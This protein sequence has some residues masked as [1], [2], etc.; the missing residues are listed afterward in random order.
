MSRS[1]TS[2]LDKGIMC[3]RRADIRLYPIQDLPRCT[4][5][6]CVGTVQ[7]SSLGN[8]LISSENVVRLLGKCGTISL[9]NVVR[10]PWEMWSDFLVKCGPIFSFLEK[11]GVNDLKTQP[12]R[13]LQFCGTPEF[14]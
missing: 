3:L 8:G 7:P 4:Y 13:F 14:P 12:N 1:G 6:N 5:A 10:F 11:F 9:G 2:A